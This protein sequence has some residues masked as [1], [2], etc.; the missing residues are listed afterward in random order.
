MHDEWIDE[1]PA[2][3]PPDS[4]IFYAPGPPSGLLGR[5][6]DAGAFD[7]DSDEDSEDDND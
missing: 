7:G 5:M 4:L 6:A 2:D 1:P 3:T